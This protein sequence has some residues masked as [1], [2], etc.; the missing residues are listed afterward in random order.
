MLE[1]RQ[2]EQVG[3][4]PEPACHPNHGTDLGK[5]SES[6]EASPGSHRDPDGRWKAAMVDAGVGSIVLALWSSSKR[7]AGFRLSWPRQPVLSAEGSARFWEIKFLWSDSSFEWDTGRIITLCKGWEKMIL[8][9]LTEEGF[10]GEK[11]S[12]DFCSAVHKAKGQQPCSS[13][14]FTRLAPHSVS[15][16]RERKLKGSWGILF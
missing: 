1:R 6:A 4:S 10:M 5:L 12:E 3:C 13:L 11:Q 2:I 7:M 15:L 8:W 9:A 16:Y 14:A